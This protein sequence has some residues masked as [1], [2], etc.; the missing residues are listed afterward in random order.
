MELIRVC[1]THPDYE[2]VFDESPIPAARF[3]NPDIVLCPFG[4]GHTVTEFYVVTPDRSRLL[5]IASTAED[6]GAW[7]P[8]EVVL[9]DD[10]AAVAK[11]RA[12]YFAEARRSISP[13][14]WKDLTAKINELYLLSQ[15]HADRLEGAK[16]HT[17]FRKAAR[18]LSLRIGEIR[19][20]IAGLPTIDN[21]RTK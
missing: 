6:G 17:F 21:R 10:K 7:I 13:K 8:E 4:A 1:P 12:E 15:R 5:A 3:A 19:M 11:C 2:V 20:A 18:S 9:L 16:V 14:T